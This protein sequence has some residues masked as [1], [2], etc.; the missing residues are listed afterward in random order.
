M[1]KNIINL[2][3]VSFYIFPSA[4]SKVNE[5]RIDQGI[6]NHSSEEQ[7]VLPISAFYKHNEWY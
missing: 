6:L 4:F 1:K 5:S 3:L 2:S 7:C